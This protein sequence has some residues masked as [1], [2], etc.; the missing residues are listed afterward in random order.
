M[1]MNTEAKIKGNIAE[2]IVSELLRELKI[3]PIRFGKEHFLP[4]I[5]QL[6]YFIKECGGEFNFT[7]VTKDFISSKT[8]LDKLPDFVGVFPNGLIHFLEIKYL[9]NARNIIEYK[10]IGD[11]LFDCYPTAH[12]LFVMSSINEEYLDIISPEFKDDLRNT[13]FHIWGREPD[14]NSIIDVR[15]PKFAVRPFFSW[16]EYDCGIKAGSLIKKYEDLVSKWLPAKSYN[17]NKG[18]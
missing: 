3:Y 10:K 17:E 16:L 7:R 9:Q 12:I 5:T 14:E 15:S 1:A 6:E 2:T 13:H 8:Y 11:S 18:K 4:P